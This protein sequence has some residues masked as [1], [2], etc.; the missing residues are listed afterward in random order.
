MIRI[1]FNLRKKFKGIRETS[2]VNDKYC[3]YYQLVARLE[4]TAAFAYF[5]AFDHHLAVKKHTRHIRQHLRIMIAGLASLVGIELHGTIL[6]RI[7][8]PGTDTS[9]RQSLR[10]ETF[11]QPVR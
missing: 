8:P 4:Q 3:R 6:G 11:C 9:H 10:L 1:P 2:A 7:C 5:G